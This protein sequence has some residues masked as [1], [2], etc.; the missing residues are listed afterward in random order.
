[1]GVVSALLMSSV[2]DER[3]INLQASAFTHD[4]LDKDLTA[5]IF[6]Y[7]TKAGFTVENEAAISAPPRVEFETGK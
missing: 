5:M 7:E 2:A 1:M 3:Q 6:G 4:T